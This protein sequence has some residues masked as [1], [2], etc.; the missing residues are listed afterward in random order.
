[1]ALLEAGDGRTYGSNTKALMDK[2][3]KPICV[4]EAEGNRVR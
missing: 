2:E 4:K 3:L 1:M